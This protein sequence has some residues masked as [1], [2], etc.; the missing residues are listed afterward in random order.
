MK[1]TDEACKEFRRVYNNTHVSPEAQVRASLTA[2]FA[3]QFSP[4]GEH[5]EL[6]N[7]LRSIDEERLN[8]EPYSCEQL[9]KKAADLIEAL[10]AR[11]APA[12][13]NDEAL[14]EAMADA[15]ADA[16]IKAIHEAKDETLV[17]DVR[18]ISMRAAFAIARPVIEEQE[19]QRWQKMLSTASQEP[20]TPK[21][22]EVE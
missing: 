16:A 18:R 3:V 2:S 20:K 9:C 5:A 13:V 4:V 15:M 14:V 22:G 7:Q 12:P 11:L 6:V 17:V 21:S 10:C 19:R 8:N 1:P